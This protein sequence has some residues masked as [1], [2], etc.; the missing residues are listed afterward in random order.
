MGEFTGIEWCDHTFNPW[1][2]CQKVSPG[3][4]N[5]YAEMLMATRYGRVKW[6]PRGVRQRTRNWRAPVNW[7][8]KAIAAGRRHTVFCASLA[9]W[10]DNKVPWEWR[11]DLRELVEQTPALDWLL[12]TKRP[13]NFRKM[14]P[15]WAKDGCPDNVWFGV[16]AEDQKHWEKRWPIAEKIK[17]RIRFVSYEPALGPLKLDY[18]VAPDWIICGGESGGKARD[19]DATWARELRDECRERG[20]YFF[21]KQ[22]AKGAMIPPDLMVRR[23]PLM[24]R[25]VL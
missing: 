3:C 9:D 8:R 20:I 22:M 7:N 11:A 4:D 2:G 16:S 21:M 15:S 23:T 19:M 6:G 10:L 24:S 18:V 17:A 13:E 12:L 25:S 14:V 5:C 1:I